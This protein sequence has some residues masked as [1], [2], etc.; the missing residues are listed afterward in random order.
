M[1]AHPNILF[2]F[3][4]E[5][6]T[7]SYASYRRTQHDGCSLDTKA[8][9]LMGN[10]IWQTLW[11]LCLLSPSEF[12]VTLYWGGYICILSLHS[13][14]KSGIYS[15]LPIFSTLKKF[16][17]PFLGM[18]KKGRWQRMVGQMILPSVQVN[19]IQLFIYFPNWPEHTTTLNTV[20]FSTS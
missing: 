4:M 16:L 12:T 18:P 5:R 20:H 10:P 11:P 17:F 15:Y 3:W 8:A 2:F 7:V 13:G 9:L 14:C 6:G 1:L 19:N